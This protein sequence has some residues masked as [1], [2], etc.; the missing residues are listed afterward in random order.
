MKN[1]NVLN[2]ELSSKATRYLVLSI[3]GVVS[4][5]TLGLAVKANAATLTRQLQQGMS[6]ADVSALQAFLAKDPTIYPQGLVTGYYGTL[7]TSAVSKFQ[8][9]NGISTVGRVGPVTMVAINAQMNGDNMAPSINSTTVNTTNSTATINWNTNE[10][11][12]AVVYYGTNYPSLTEGA[13]VSIGGSSTLA[14]TDLRSSHSATLSSL[15]SNTTYYYVLYVRDAEGN[16]SISWPATFK[17]T[18]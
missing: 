16:E 7:T 9:K 3:V 6:G 12:S 8:A 13:N 10:N 5:L 15:N 14:H 11:S 1:L 17:T 4:M 2:N 18:N